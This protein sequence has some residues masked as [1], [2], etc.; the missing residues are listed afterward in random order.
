[1]LKFAPFCSPCDALL[2]G[3]VV[4]LPKSKF[5]D[6]GQKPWFD[7]GRPKKVARKVWHSIENE[8]RKLI[9]FVSVA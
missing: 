2:P 5:S 4:F 3:I 7:F 9:A 8:K 6:F 1:M